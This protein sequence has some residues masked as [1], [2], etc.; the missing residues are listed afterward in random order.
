MIGYTIC[1]LTCPK[2]QFIDANIPF[3]CQ[4]CAP[5]CDA[6]EVEATRCII[7]EGCAQGYYYNNL[8]NTCIAACPDAYY[9]D[10]ITGFC[11]DCPGGCLTC[12]SNSYEDCQTCGV[13]IFN[14]S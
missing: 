4:Q 8:T 14:A 1:S 13:N 7:T 12:T 6:C 3:E 9:A 10:V 2:G 11:E 5:E